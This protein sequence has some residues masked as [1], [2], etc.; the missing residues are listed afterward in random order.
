MGVPFTA[1]HG[2][3]RFSLSRDNTEAQI[4]R[5]VEVVPPIV[6]RLRDL[7]PF[8]SA[9]VPAASAFKPEYA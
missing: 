1:A 2:S 6:G 4:D 9:G 8:W 3:I 7:S 5:V